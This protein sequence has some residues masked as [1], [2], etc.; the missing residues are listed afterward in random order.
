[1]L[2]ENAKGGY[3]FLAGIAPYSSGVIAMPGYEIIHAIFKQPL[4]WREGFEAVDAHLKGIGRNR[5]ALCGIELRCPTPY[6]MD[7]F[8]DFN[9]EYCRVLKDWDLFVDGHNPVARTNVAPVLHAPVTPVL[10][11]FSYTIPQ[12]EDGLQTLVVAGAG[13]LA[14]RELVS[15]G[16]LRRGEITSDAMRE[17]AMYV[18]GVMDKRLMGLGGTWDM[19]RAGRDRALDR[20]QTQ[21]VSWVVGDAQALPFPDR[22][23][24]VV[25]IAFGLRNVAVIPAALREMRRVLKP[26]GTF[27]CLEFSPEV[28]PLL[29]R[30]YDLYSFSVLPRLGAVVAGDADSYVYLVESIRRFP[31]RDTL[32]SLLGDAGFERVRS[33]GLSGGIAAIH[34]GWRL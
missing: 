29:R 31:D 16:I 34:Q 12:Q 15:D 24:D 1:M 5:K 27:L 28:L 6:T 13:E 22:A 20:G 14:S 26:G 3:R 11:A 25:T 9:C 2:L 33:Q 10:H 4:P 7:G 30:A 23:V 18:M 19:V 21:S 32:S 8:I 17:K